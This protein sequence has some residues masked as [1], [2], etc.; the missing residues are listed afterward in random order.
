MWCLFFFFF[1]YVPSVSLCL[2]SV[3]AK[4]ADFTRVRRFS[5]PCLPI[6]GESAYTDVKGHGTKVMPLTSRPCVGSL[7]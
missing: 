7:P 4:A 1:F 6:S 3:L 5:L 2:R